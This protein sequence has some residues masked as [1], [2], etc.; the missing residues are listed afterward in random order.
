M[1]GGGER[2]GNFIHNFFLFLSV[3]GRMNGVV[4]CNK[5]LTNYIKK[6]DRRMDLI[7]SLPKRKRKI[8]RTHLTLSHVV[9]R[10]AMRVCKILSLSIGWEDNIVVV[11]SFCSTFPLCQS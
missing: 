6:K 5:P 4:S 3:F 2:E 8:L 7:P 1:D 10:K 11:F 9:V